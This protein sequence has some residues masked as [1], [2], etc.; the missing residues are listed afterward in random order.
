M[1]IAQMVEV[2]LVTSRGRGELHRGPLHER[3]D[4]IRRDTLD[5]TP[6]GDSFHV[7]GV[8]VDDDMILSLHGDLNLRSVP[9]LRAVLDG[10]V[11]L[12]PHRLVID[13]SEVNQ[14]SLD[15]LQLIAHC[16]LQI[17]DVV[18]RSP[19]PTTR[20]DLV[21]LGRS[22]LLEPALASSHSV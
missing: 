18:M 7:S 6:S 10:L 15:A 9:N 12:Q 5:T 1:T 17:D 22:D 20:A 21:R 19:S 3:P 2:A 8:H 14:V 16:A 4:S 11:L 13:L